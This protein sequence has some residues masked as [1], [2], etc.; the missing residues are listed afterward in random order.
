MYVCVCI[1]IHA[2]IRIHTNTH[3]MELWQFF[4]PIFDITVSITIITSVVPHANRLIHNDWS[5]EAC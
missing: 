3:V 5:K 4:I 1:N 2:Y